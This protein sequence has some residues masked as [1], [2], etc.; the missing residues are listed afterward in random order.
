M[1]ILNGDTEEV[2][3]EGDFDTFNECVNAAVL[4]KVNLVFA[5]LDGA[6]LRDADLNDVDSLQAAFE[7]W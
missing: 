4:E 3:F 7:G 1:K 2:L 6:N 5:N